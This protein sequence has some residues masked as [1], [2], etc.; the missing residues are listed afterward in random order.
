MAINESIAVLLAGGPKAPSGTSGRPLPPPLPPPLSR[1]AGAHAAC[2]FYVEVGT[3]GSGREIQA[4]FTEV[5]GLQVEMQVMDYEEGGV[6]NYIRRLPG[7][8]KVGNVTLKR[9]LTKS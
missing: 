1:A 6:N 5:S 2:R 9:G 4:L 7:R 8:L 3:K